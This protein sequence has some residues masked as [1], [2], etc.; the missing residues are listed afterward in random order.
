[1]DFEGW[2]YLSRNSGSDPTKVSV[3]KPLVYFGSFQDLLSRDAA[4]NIKP[5]NKWLHKIKWDLVI[6]DEYHFGAC[7]RRLKNSSRAR[8]RRRP[9]KKP[10]WNTPMGWR[11]ST[12]ISLCSLKRSPSSCHHHQGLPLPLRHAVPGAG[13]GRVHRGADFQLDLHRRAARQGRLR[14]QPSERAQPLRRVAAVASAY[15]PNAG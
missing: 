12:K 2:Q 13:H 15:L 7:G 11:I 8:K 9:E 4:G 3:K 6:F 1:V 10:N 5:K 14:P